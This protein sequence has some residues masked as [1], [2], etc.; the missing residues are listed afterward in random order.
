MEND[1][2]LHRQRNAFTLVELLVVIGIIA[3][4]ISLLLPALGKARGSAETIQCASN[5]RQIGQ[6]IQ[7]FAS[8]NNGQAPGTA[9]SVSKGGGFIWN[10]ILNAEHFN[11]AEFIWTHIPT[12]GVQHKNAKLFCPTKWKLG[13]RTMS[14]SP[15]WFARHY[16]VNGWVDGT[17]AGS[18]GVQ[19]ASPERKNV[20]YTREG[21]DISNLVLNSYRYG[22]KLSKFRQP[23][24]KYVIFDANPLSNN[25]IRAN[26]NEFGTLA[27][28]TT[29]STSR[30]AGP[31]AYIH[32]GRRSNFLFVDGHVESR[33]FSSDAHKSKYFTLTGRP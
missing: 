24:E 5:M 26:P 25:S 9:G 17:T 31:F 21:T 27:L 15:F 18:G 22:A 2:I 3:V 12:N 10:E 16:T 19:I 33:A 13:Y 6:A 23:T 28:G 1:A 30:L 29:P 11:R 8:A 4:L 7:M 32:N 14:A 20:H